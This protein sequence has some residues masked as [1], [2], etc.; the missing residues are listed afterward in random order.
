[1][2]ERKKL[3]VLIDHLDPM[4][5]GYAG[6]LQAAFDTECR[7]VNHDLLMVVG[8]SL[9]GPGAHELAQNT[10]YDLIRPSS[11]DGVILVA[12]GLASF[13]GA[14]RLA[15]YCEHFRPLPLCSVGLSIPGVP[16]IIIDPRPGLWDLMDHLVRRHSCSRIA[17]IAGPEQ[18]PEARQRLDIYKECLERHGLVFDPVL[19]EHCP[20]TLIGGSEAT[21]RMLARTPRPQAF[22]AANDV[23][24]LGVIKALQSKGLKVPAD[25]IVTGF[26]DLAFARFSSPPLTTVRQ[27]LARMAALAV[28][29]LQG[30]L[31]GIHSLRSTELPVELTVRDSCGC[32]EI[33][34]EAP[35]VSNRVMMHPSDYLEAQ[36]SRIQTEL[37]NNLDLKAG[38][39]PGWSESL[40]QGLKLEF[41]GDKGAFASCLDELLA[42]VDAGLQLYDELQKMVTRLRD[43]L[44]AVGSPALEEVWHA[45]RRSIARAN[46]QG[47]A[48]LRQ[49]LDL[50]YQHL[51]YTG[52]RFASAGDRTRLKAAMAEALP[53]A[54][55]KQALVLL[56]QEGTRDKLVPFFCLREGVP[57][58]LEPTPY[59][60]TLL[61]PPNAPRSA[62]RTTAFVLPLTFGSEALGVAV[63]G[64]R[65]GVHEMLRV[66]ISVALQA[67]TMQQRLEALSTLV[68]SE[69]LSA[70]EQRHA[71]ERIATRLKQLSGMLGAVAQDLERA[72]GEF[73]EAGGAGGD[74]PA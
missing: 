32:G 9:G 28:R 5:G 54:N 3:A 16:S 21:T 69:S 56:Y 36:A 23:L 4:V 68:P 13:S 44:S 19:V 10:A 58:D 40:V 30:Q 8:R 61:L 45:A 26:D 47:H 60:A 7:K 12:G 66:Q 17:L 2:S 31:Q 22:V 34:A 64:A 59:P 20:F 42:S 43:G 72:A 11:V 55:V 18:N 67:V 24:A 1:M 35:P 74:E 38:L 39:P 65:S 71:S 27:P 50:V 33:E 62:E 57:V 14:T 51:L 70:D 49:E 52:E 29:S 48:R 25:V 63:F 37:A 15:E 6:Q 41:A 53:R 73:A 46:S